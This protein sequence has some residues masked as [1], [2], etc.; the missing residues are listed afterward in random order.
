MVWNL[1]MRFKSKLLVIFAF[2]ARLPVIA[3]AAVRLHY[4]HERFLG[5]SDT[6]EYLVATQW[7]MGY[8]IMASTITGL[9]PFLRPFNKEY[10]TS[11]QQKS[12]YGSQRSDM[13]DNSQNAGPTG[14]QSRGSWNSEGYLMQPVISR[15]GTR[16]TGEGL[17]R[18]FILGD[19][20][21]IHR[22]TA[23][24]S[25]THEAYRDSSSPQTPNLLTA[26]ANF[27]P[28][29]N[30]LR[31]DTEI[32]VG[33]RTASFGAEEDMPTHVG[34]NKALIINKRTQFKVEVDRASR[35]L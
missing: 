24:E 17:A 15:R 3:I 35:V 10:T 34:E 9:G 32:W 1:Q 7:Q 23:S 30:I 12:N 8:A 2:S 11:Y 19:S 18:P 21:S 22:S 27:R 13:A 16:T 25:S 33:D 20:F 6:F 29:G 31:N 4:L 28:F 5:R 14:S 26:G